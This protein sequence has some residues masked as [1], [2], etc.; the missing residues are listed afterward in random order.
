MAQGLWGRADVW[1]F[2]SLELRSLVVFLYEWNELR[3]WRGNYARGKRGSCFLWSLSWEAF[4]WN[5]DK[6]GRFTYSNWEAGGLCHGQHMLVSLSFLIR[7]T[8][9]PC[10]LLPVACWRV[11]ILRLKYLFLDLLW[12]E[13]N[14]LKKLSSCPVYYVEYHSPTGTSVGTQYFKMWIRCNWCHYAC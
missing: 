12:R 11:R 7:L 5:G 8:K 6:K 2:W 10:L 1:L 9:P 4:E 14:S 13:S 3:V